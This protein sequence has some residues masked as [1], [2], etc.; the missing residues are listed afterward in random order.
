M[1]RATMRPT[2]GGEDLR[3]GENTLACELYVPYNPR[4]SAK[5]RIKSEEN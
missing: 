4:T 5:I 1:I 3:S 2:K